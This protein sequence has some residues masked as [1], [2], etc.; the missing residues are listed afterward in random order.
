MSL[1][2][3]IVFLPKKKK[4]PTIQIVYSNLSSIINSSFC[5]CDLKAYLKRESRLYYESNSISR[6]VK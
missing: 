4:N 3:Q 2:I 1:T 5:M 6:F